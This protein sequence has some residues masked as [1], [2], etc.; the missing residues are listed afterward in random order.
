MANS[1]EITGPVLCRMLSWPS[2][3]K[4]HGFKESVLCDVYDGEQWATAVL[5]DDHIAPGGELGRNLVFGVCGNGVDPMEHKNHSL[6]PLPITCF[7]L[8]ARLRYTLP[9][10]GLVC[11]IPPN[12]KGGEPAGFQPFMD[13][14]AD[15]MRYLYQYGVQV[16]DGSHRR[17]VLPPGLFVHNHC[18]FVHTQ[19]MSRPCTLTCMASMHVCMCVCVCATHVHVYI[20]FVITCNAV[21]TQTTVI[22]FLQ[23]RRM[24][25]ECNGIHESNS[26]AKTLHTLT[27]CCRLSVLPP[28]IRV[29]L[30]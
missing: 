20:A 9:A 14:F 7:N 27:A 22:P 19:I 11:I 8:P 21:A 10:L 18:L 25:A 29:Y 3:R 2:E 16:F 15:Q 4:Q 26:A 17:A 24:C 13:I 6:W 1:Q 23:M 5:G 12:S 30:R 28:Q